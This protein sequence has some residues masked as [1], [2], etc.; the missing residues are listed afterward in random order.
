MI[1]DGVHGLLVAPRR[2][3]L[4]AEA[5][6]RLLGDRVAARSLGERARQRVVEE[7]DLR[8][9]VDTLLTI[10]DDVRAS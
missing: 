6:D 1:D 7:F 10:Y 8:R 2:P 4:L 9:S 5:V 3:D